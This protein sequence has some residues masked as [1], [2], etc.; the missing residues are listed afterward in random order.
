LS[1]ISEKSKL[2]RATGWAAFLP[3]TLVGIYP[4]GASE[5][6]QFPPHRLFRKVVNWGSGESYFKHPFLVESFGI[7]TSHS[8]TIARAYLALN[9]SLDGGGRST[10]KIDEKKI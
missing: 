2:S 5:I 8:S 9:I 10:K 4:D 7:Q 1:R 3:T 6:L